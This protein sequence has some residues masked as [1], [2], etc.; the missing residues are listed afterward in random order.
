MR[1]IKYDKED[2]IWEATR[3]NEIYKTLYNG[4]VNEKVKQN[5]LREL[6][7]L[8]FLVD[9]TI[10]VDTIK[11]KVAS[12]AEPREIH[13]YNDFFKRIE[14]PVIHHVVPYVL[15]YQSIL[16]ASGENRQ[17]KADE[18]TLP[19]TQFE[20]WLDIF[21]KESQGRILVSIDPSASDKSIWDAIKKLKR[22]EVKDIK[23]FYEQQPS[24]P[25]SYRPR[26]IDKYI[27][28]LKKYDETLKEIDSTNS[29]KTK[30][31][32]TIRALPEGFSF[33]SMVPNRN[34]KYE[35]EYEFEDIR[36]AYRDAYDEA[37]ELIK[38]SPYISFSESRAQK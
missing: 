20:I 11:E 34:E 7:R 15:Y 29:E 2:L 14:N 5:I 21:L 10:T 12:G 28:W 19:I 16:Q 32:G 31:E 4:T 36:R 17:D 30:I 35:N 1:K 38:I 23:A 8:N 9:P 18:N 25:K 22:K 24:L 6:F 3:R 13:P 27:G 37:V 26:D 33:T